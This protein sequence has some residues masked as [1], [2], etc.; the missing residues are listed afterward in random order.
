M[1]M[2]VAV[3]Q[4]ADMSIIAYI[5]L[6]CH[7]VEDHVKLVKVLLGVSH[8]AAAHTVASSSGATRSLIWEWDLEGKW[9]PVWLIQEPVC[10]L[11]SECIKT[12]TLLCPFFKFSCKEDSRCGSWPRGTRAQKLLSLFKTRTSLKKKKLRK[13]LEQMNRPA[14]KLMQEVNTYWKSTFLMLQCLLKVRQSVGAAP[15]RY[16]CPLVTVKQ[17]WHAWI[18]SLLFSK[19]QWNF[20][21]KS[22]SESKVISMVKMLMLHLYDTIWRN[23]HKSKAR[24]PNSI[25]HCWIQDLY[26]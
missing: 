10:K 24:E 15:M 5:P 2:V 7:Y 19:Q 22:V 6:T 17:Q 14:K 23:S 18:Y 13:V 9:P 20:K 11:L 12:C 26:P 8:F 25:L 21:E 16:L 1:V 4:I 3:S